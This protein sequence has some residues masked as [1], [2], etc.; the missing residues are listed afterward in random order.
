MLEEIIELYQNILRYHKESLLEFYR[1]YHELDDSTF[2]EERRERVVYRLLS[3][4]FEVQHTDKIITSFH[5]DPS[6]K[7]SIVGT[8]IKEKISISTKIKYYE[9]EDTFFTVS[10]HENSKISG[11]VGTIVGGSPTFHCADK[12]RMFWVDLL[13]KDQ[14]FNLSMRTPLISYNTYLVMRELYPNVPDGTVIKIKELF[15]E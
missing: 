14:H 11:T 8:I 7:G 5:K 2:T 4:V 10:R 6:G 1:V 9:S 13:D 12:V 15:N 3:K